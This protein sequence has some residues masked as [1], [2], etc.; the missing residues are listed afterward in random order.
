M[1]M[2]LFRLNKRVDNAVSNMKITLNSNGLLLHSLLFAFL[3]LDTQALRSQ[4]VEFVDGKQIELANVGEVLRINELVRNQ[5]FDAA[6]KAAVDFHSSDIRGFF[7][8]VDKTKNN[9]RLFLPAKRFLDLELS[10]WKVAFP[11]AYVKYRE[12]IDAEANLMYRAAKQARDSEALQG[13]V[14]KY[15]HSQIGD[16]AADLLAKFH[17]ESGEF[18]SAMELWDS[19]I[20]DPNFPVRSLLRYPDSNL[21]PM[22][23][24]ANSMFASLFANDMA[25]ADQKL[26]YLK[27]NYANSRFNVL[28]E[29]ELP[30]RKL[31]EVFARER[32]LMTSTLGRN[33]SLSQRVSDRQPVDI[34]GR[35]I[36]VN[37][38]NAI[39]KSKSPTFQAY[40]SVSDGA[41]QSITTT[42][43]MF[44]G[45]AY[46][47][48]EHQV[49]KRSTESF[50]GD[51]EVIWETLLKNET[52]ETSRQKIGNPRFDVVISDGKLFARMGDSRTTYRNDSVTRNRSYLIGLNL[53]R[54]GRSLP[55]FPV[56]NEDSRIEFESTPLFSNGKLFALKRKSYRDNSVSQLF[57]ECLELSPSNRLSQP[58]RAWLT[59]LGSGNTAGQAIADEVSNVRVHKFR[60]R[61]VVAASGFVGCLNAQNGAVEWVADYPR[62]RFETQKM[63]R[64][65]TP[66]QQSYCLEKSGKLF[67]APTDSD[68]IY[69][70]DLL[71]GVNLWKTQ[72]N[73]TAHVL[74]QT[75]SHLLVSGDQLFWL[76]IKTGVVDAA[77]PMGSN[78][79]YNSFGLPSPRGMG[80]GV[81]SDKWIYWPTRDRIFVFSSELTNSKSPRLSKIIDL[82]MRQMTGGNL[83]IA[84]GIMLIATEDRLFAFGE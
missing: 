21:S 19:L 72:L 77:F 35:P 53:R 83:M 27:L 66:R 29:S 10:S 71:T 49:Y 60:N 33:D 24:M 75:D 14:S 48:D 58:K 45:A 78:V 16:E 51:E 55:G 4:E 1:Q 76:S 28:G 46:W 15:F 17:F 3:I 32:V 64:E 65:E 81:I 67:V 40:S 8:V 39:S 36:W 23:L 25:T 7:R 44:S 13:V 73:R 37:P 79:G 82:K 84:N 50:D 41:S 2:N 68:F 18:Y 26:K 74:G 11:E 59:E 5:A 57:V 20:H 42:V 69:C 47:C 34:K 52:V 56:S 12:L 63:F 54:G 38:I 31:D 43:K 30:F 80:Q 62:D 70:F 61:I 22:D 6:A 9:C